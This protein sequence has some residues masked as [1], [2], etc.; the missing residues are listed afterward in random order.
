MKLMSALLGLALG[1][2][3]ILFALGYFSFSCE[4]PVG[5]G[6]SP[7]E[8]SS[9]EKSM[10]EYNISKEKELNKNRQPCD[11]IAFRE[12]VINNFPAGTHLVEF[13]RTFTY[14][15]P[16]PAVIYYKD[17]NK[18]YIF[19]LIAKSKEGERFI[20]KKNVVGYESSFINLDST[21]LGTAFFFL[22]LFTCNN[23]EFTQLWEAETPMHG[24][25]NSMKIKKWKFKNTLYV[26]LNFEDGIISGHRN[27]NFFLIDGIESKPHLLETYVGI[28]NKRTMANVNNDKYPDYYEYRFN[29]HHWQVDSLYQIKV[30]DSIPFY[31]SEKRQLYITNKNPRWYRKY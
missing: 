21:K 6:A 24:G 18:T 4:G 16:K 31:W 8:S 3:M 23:G 5:G 26:E 14:N 7:E 13:D 1:V 17:K 11:T 22:T 10:K 27:F 25:F 29:A 28:V 30:L 9:K 2:I 19:A 20:E 12:Y 15:I